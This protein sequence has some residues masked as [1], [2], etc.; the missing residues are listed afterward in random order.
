MTFTDI[1]KVEVATILVLEG[2]AALSTDIV[3]T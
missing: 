1:E 2:E 3:E